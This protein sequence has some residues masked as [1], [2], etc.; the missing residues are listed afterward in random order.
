MNMAD[1]H[2]TL[3]R[4]G[5]EI[6]DFMLSKIGSGHIHQTY[7][8]DGINKYIL[9]NLNTR[10]FTR[11]EEVMH[12]ISLAAEYILK[13]DK[14][15]PFSIPLK[16]V[17]GKN[18]VY[19]STGNVWRLFKAIEGSTTIDEVANADQAYSAAKAFGKFTRLLQDAGTHQFYEIIPGFHDLN[20]R[21]KQFEQALDNAGV[22][23]KNQANN[24]I[25]KARSFYHLVMEYN[26][27]INSGMLVKRIM[28]ND[29]KINNV[30]FN[31]SGDAFS[32]IDL[33]TLM[34]G[35]FIYD[36]GD[37]VRTFVSPVN[38]EAKDLSK[39][40]FRKEIYDA[41]LIG[42]LSEMDG[43][44][45]ADEKSA[46]PFASKMM[47]YIMALRFLT[48]YLNGDLYYPIKYEAHNLDRA[49]NQLNL[50][51]KLEAEKLTKK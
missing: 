26:T 38:E 40:I 14:T 51:A 47:T 12:N 24:S 17:D 8:L 15:Y 44:L 27:L 18:L 6:D 7:L 9:Q 42:Y 45:T 43:V 10:V 41:L 4:F 19:D 37:M 50:L 21:Y 3:R 31:K 28:H 20:L 46:I 13:I 48:D 32:V 29:T 39:I 49:A 2:A 16:S 35:Y 30:L 34:P 22:E 25:E 5:L 36:L 23:R 1:L 11:P 33:D